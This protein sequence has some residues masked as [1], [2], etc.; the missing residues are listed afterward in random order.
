MPLG[1]LVLVL[2]AGAGIGALLHQ[3][4]SGSTNAASG[5]APNAAGA[6]TTDE[7]LSQWVHSV[8][9]PSYS[10]ETNQAPAH[11][12]A[13]S[14]G[15]ME[16]CTGIPQRAGFTVETTSMRQFQG[17][18]AT[19]VVYQNSEEPA[20]T[21]VYA[22]CVGYVGLPCR[23]LRSSEIARIRASG[24]PMKASRSLSSARF[25]LAPTIVFTT[26]PPT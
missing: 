23:R 19:L 12:H 2:A 14:L 5:T 6:K 26:S 9:V 7:A 22:R 13:S 16:Q 18:E 3:A 1:A 24:Q 10:A 25:G 8:L 15:P 4:G 21:T 17:R 11:P 20:S